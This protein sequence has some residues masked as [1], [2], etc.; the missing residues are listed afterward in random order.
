[1]KP[2][3]C[4][5][6]LIVCES[7]AQSNTRTI[8]ETPLSR[9]EARQVLLETSKI[10]ET[11]YLYPEKGKAAL[12]RL[13]ADFTTNVD[14]QQYGFSRLK[15]Q[16][17]TLLIE[18]TGDSNFELLLE[19]SLINK[20]GRR[21]NYASIQS[22]SDVHVE[23]LEGNIGYLKLMGDLV[24]ADDA[25]TI[26]RAIEFIKD[27]QAIVIDLRQ[28]DRA[29]IELI[30][31]LAGHFVKTGTVLGSI[32]YHQQNE[33]KRITTHLATPAFDAN[34]PIYILNSAFVEGAWEL[35]GTAMQRQRSAIVVGVETMGIE[36]LIIRARL[37]KNLSL[38]YTAAE[39]VSSKAEQSWGNTG[40]IPDFNIPVEEALEFA[41]EHAVSKSPQH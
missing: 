18:V 16:L 26:S 7:I 22:K 34:V 15:H 25:F 31:H 23:L 35:F 4:I 32:A 6:L 37:T 21:E 14:S 12:D 17:E 10:L 28:A 40:V 38:Q 19:D 11:E 30:Q 33:T 9:Q 2:L 3:M 24:N 5:L 41:I 36:K 27:S 13:R 39:I 20:M 1:M 8:I 29:P